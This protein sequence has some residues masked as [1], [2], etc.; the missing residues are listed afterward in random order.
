[1]SCFNFK[2]NEESDIFFLEIANKMVNYFKITHE[3]AIGRI[4]KQWSTVDTTIDF[5]YITHELTSDWAYIV[6]YG[7]SSRWWKRKDDPTLKPIPYP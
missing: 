6:Y 5:D 4:N 7:H 2:T 1:M 3:E